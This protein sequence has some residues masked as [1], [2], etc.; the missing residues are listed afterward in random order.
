MDDVDNFT[1]VFCSKLESAV[2][3]E[4]QRV[5]IPV[6]GIQDGEIKVSRTGVLYRIAGYHF[7]LTASHDL[8]GTVEAGIPLYV[9]PNEDDPKGPILS[10]READFHPSEEDG[11]DVAAIRLTDEVAAQVIPY[12]SFI[13][14]DRI[15]PFGRPANSFYYF[16]GFPQQF[17]G[18]ALSGA[19]HTNPIGVFC[20]EYTGD[21]SSGICYLPEVHAVLE[22]ESQ[23]ICFRNGAE[24]EPPD[25]HGISG[26]GIWRVCEFTREGMERCRPEDLRLV[27]LEHGWVRGKYVLATRI[28]Y[29]LQFVAA[30]YPELKRSMSIA[31]PPP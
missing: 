3:P 29:A 27:A 2:I 31:Y 22:F 18:K 30:R 25:I 24:L 19:L 7:I 23:G 28:E 5:T 6:Y 8:R 14:N 20:S 4:I 16:L 13:Q 26:C 12:K 1:K 10:L 15:A 9:L 17:V 11:R 21:I